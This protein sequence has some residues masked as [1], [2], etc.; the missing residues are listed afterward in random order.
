M[1]PFL[2]DPAFWEDFH[3]RFITELADHLLERLPDTYDA[4]IDE[5]VR[6]VEADQGSVG[7]RL[8]NVSVDQPID[9]QAVST[10]RSGGATATLEPVSV[11]MLMLQEHRDVWIE[12]VH[13]PERRLVTAIEVLSPSNKEGDDAVEYHAKRKPGT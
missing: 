10:S 9:Q 3:R 12:I 8:P 11:P 1:D 6:L 4:H 5:R 7:T 2:E 13:L